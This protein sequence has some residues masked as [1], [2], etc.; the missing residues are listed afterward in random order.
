MAHSGLIAALLLIPLGGFEGG[1]GGVWCFKILANTRKY[2]TVLQPS[3]RNDGP[4]I[5]AMSVF[6]F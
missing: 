4:T 6:V 3:V 2:T 1:G 5:S